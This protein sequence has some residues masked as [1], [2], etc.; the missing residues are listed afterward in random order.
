MTYAPAP[1][2]VGKL[3]RDAIR[4]AELTQAAVAER[5]GMSQSQLSRRLA[6]KL[7]LDV[8]ELDVIAEMCGVALSDLVPAGR[9]LAP[10][11]SRRTARR[12]ARTDP[13]TVAAV[14]AAR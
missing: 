10:T 11:G 12:P 14:A 6:G 3:A 4:D 5:L 9:D 8:R 1:A 7:V 13:A 2:L